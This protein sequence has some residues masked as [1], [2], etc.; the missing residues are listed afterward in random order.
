MPRRFPMRQRDKPLD[1]DYGVDV[2]LFI[3]AL[4]HI[5]CDILAEE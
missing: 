3:F 1:A 2:R 4:L 5:C